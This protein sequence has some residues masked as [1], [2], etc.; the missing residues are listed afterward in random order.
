[1]TSLLEFNALRDDLVRHIDVLIQHSENYY[2]LCSEAVERESKPGGRA[3]NLIRR[4]AGH[5][6]VSR[7]YRLIEGSLD[8]NNVSKLMAQ[9]ADD[10]LLEQMFLHFNHDGRKTFEELSSLRD[11]V[12]E[13]FA[14]VRN[15]DFFKKVDIYRNRFVAHRAPSPRNLNKFPPNA[16]VTVLSSAELRWLTDSLCAIA[17]KINYMADRNSFPAEDIAWLAKCEAHE[18]WGLAPPEKKDFLDSFF[19]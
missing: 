6:I 2:V 4:A 19:D 17:N 5:E 10:S 15:S 9:L 1:M 11:D 18:L 13:N 7:L 8:A 12:L 3:F 14:G 16:N